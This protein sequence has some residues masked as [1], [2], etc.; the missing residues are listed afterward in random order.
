MSFI[1]S[2]LAGTDE[3]GKPRLNQ[4]VIDGVIQIEQELYSME[5]TILKA[6]EKRVLSVENIIQ[7]LWEKVT[8]KVIARF[9]QAINFITSQEQNITNILNAR[10]SAVESRTRDFELKELPL[11]GT[12]PEEQ[13]GILPPLPP[14]SLPMKP[15]QDC[16]PQQVQVNIKV[17]HETKESLPKEP[18]VKVDNLQD[19]EVQRTDEPIAESE[20]E[21]ICEAKT[22]TE[23]GLTVCGKDM[24]RQFFELYGLP[25]MTD[26]EIREAIKEIPVGWEKELSGPPKERVA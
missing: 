11:V 13:I 21:E 4:N 20:G 6:L 1:Q 2:Y 5:E 26:D 12:P 25:T 9:E 19:G 8:L 22:D 7:K 18:L 10:I 23:F 24:I 16:P 17:E 15:S 14:T 3:C